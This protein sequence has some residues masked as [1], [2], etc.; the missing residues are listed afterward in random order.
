MIQVGIIMCNKLVIFGCGGHAKS[1]LDVV[2]FNKDYDDIV[3]VDFDAKQ[4]E[5]ILGFSVL[6]SYKVTREDVFVAVGNNA[7]RMKLSEKYYSNLVSIV[8][9]RAYIGR[10][11]VLKKGVFIA[12]N[13]HIGIMSRIAD[14]CIINTSASLDHEC[15]LGKSV[16][17]GPNATLCGKV[18][19][20]DNSFV[21]AGTVVIENIDVCDNIVIG[22]SSVVVNDLVEQGTYVGSPVRLVVKNH[23]GSSVE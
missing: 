22:A 7:Q 4:G 9:K 15:S 14:Y 11:V 2:L 18:S 13:V 12:H 17:I 23:K 1:V 21:G 16:F 5:T 19:I 10:D 3:F 8:S 6:K 20:G